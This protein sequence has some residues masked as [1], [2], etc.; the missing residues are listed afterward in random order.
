MYIE[1]LV[2]Q[3][4]RCFGNQRTVV[5]LEPGLTPFIGSNGAGKTAACQALQRLFGIT[6]DERAVRFDD[7]HVPAGESVLEGESGAAQPRTL[8]IEAILAFPELDDDGDQG[9]DAVPE[10]FHRM[11]ADSEGTLKCRI[12]LEARWEAD[13]TVDGSLSSKLWVVDTLDETYSEDHRTGLPVAERGRIQVVYVP[14]SRDGARQL[15]A[16]LR[17]RLWRAAQWSDELRDLVA[18]S[19]AEVSGK[20]HDEAATSTV[21]KAL[22]QR[23]QELHGGGTHSIPRFQPIAPDV[24]E[25]LRDT[26]LRFEPDHGGEGRPARMLS[27]G[28]RSMLHLALTTAA[29]DIETRVAGGGLAGEF[30]MTSAH[31]P[32]LTVLIVEEPENSLAPFY[33]SRIVS[34]VLQVCDGPRAQAVL[35]SHSA[36]VLS[37]IDPASIR[38][39]RLDAAAGTAAVRPITLPDNATEAGK[40]VREAVRAHPELYFARFVVLGEGDTEELIIP[41]VAQARGIALDPSFVAMVPLG[42][43]HT[44][45]FWKLLTDLNIPF[46]TLLDFD[47]GRADAGPARLRVACRRLADNGVDIFAGLDG[48][49]TAEDLTDAMTVRQMVDVMIHLREFGVFFS[50]PLDLDMA[51][52]ISFWKAYTELDP[53]ERGPRDSDATDAV[54]GI[55]G[56]PGEF[57]APADPNDLARQ[58]ERLRWYRYL[59]LGRSK[60]STHLRALAR[61]SP[62]ELKDGP[63]E[64]CA[65]SDYIKMKLGL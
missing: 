10:F 48:F 59:F 55:G 61:L 28:Q 21:E 25:L 31:L 58:Q 51:M 38:H 24:A 6:N 34:Q 30:D 18:S 63:G 27:D 11:A 1:S 49:S 23:W 35:V 5:S 54:L 60:P 42:G 26:E 12:V 32:T 22:S 29:L 13:G 37:R 15:T 17:S 16:F 40:Y 9:K 44:N 46:A 7:F 47:Y 14:A 19:A 4:F 36:S 50:T 53:E 2:L 45:H 20:F 43:R 3:N 64:V 39:F 65:L 8:A 57:W 41:A 33:L 62:A 56:S 52:L